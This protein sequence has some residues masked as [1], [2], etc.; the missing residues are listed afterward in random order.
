MKLLDLFLIE[1]NDEFVNK[2]P[3]KYSYIFPKKERSLNHFRYSCQAQRKIWENVEIP[4]KIWQVCS[5]Y[6]G[7]SMIILSKGWGSQ[8]LQ[9]LFQEITKKKILKRFCQILLRN[10]NKHFSRIS[11]RFLLKIQTPFETI[12]K[13]QL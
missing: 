2:F 10:C 7:I 8:K 1:I 9:Q 12:K 11:N 13:L 6:S 4:D 3:K 5:R